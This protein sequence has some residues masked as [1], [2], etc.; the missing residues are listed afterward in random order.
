M[1]DALPPRRTWTSPTLGV[2]FEM[3]EDG[4]ALFYPGGECFKDPEE[5]FQ[6]RNQTQQTLERAMAKL[7]ELGINPEELE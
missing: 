1:V 5:L 7:R 6:E 3:F 4:L 2:K